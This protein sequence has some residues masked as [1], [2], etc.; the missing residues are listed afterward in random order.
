MAQVNPV[1]ADSNSDVNVVIDE[2]LCTEFPGNDPQLLR[3]RQQFP[4]R[5]VLLAELHSRN[6]A[7][8]GKTDRFGKRQLRLL[9][10]RYQ[11]EFEV[12]WQKMLLLRM[13][14]RSKF[15]DTDL[16]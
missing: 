10:I 15:I 9:P 11:V 5:K 8:Q 1:G 16:H 14:D 2:Q 4:N 12:D 7:Q 6:S 13:M 3:Q